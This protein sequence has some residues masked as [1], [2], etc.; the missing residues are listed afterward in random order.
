MSDPYFF[1]FDIINYSE[2]I[3]GDNY[4][5]KLNNKVIKN[6]LDNRR[7]LPVTR[8]SGTF[9]RL[10]TETENQNITEYAVFKNIR[11]M[12]K[13]YKKGHCNQIMIRYPYGYLASSNSCDMFSDSNPNPILRKT[14]NEDI[15]VFLNLN[16][17]I[18]GIP[19]QQNIISN[20]AYSMLETKIA[21]DTVNEVRFF[22]G[23]NPIIGGK[24]S[25]KNK[26]IYKKKR[27]NKNKKTKKRYH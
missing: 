26:K 1:P 3:P 16:K 7:A 10:H 14:I 18:F 12:N 6:F 15:E 20:K 13:N 22:K 11:I 21:P 4:Y 24:K 17:W 23:D 27:I 25:I 9:V 8:L 19:S 5:I 2:L